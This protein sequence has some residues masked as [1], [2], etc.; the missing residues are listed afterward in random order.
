VTRS[1]GSLDQGARVVRRCAIYTRVATATD[2][3][4]ER[5]LLAAQRARC[6]TLIRQRASRGWQLV[7]ERYD[8][9]GCSGG[10]LDR[11][12]LG[13]LLAAIDAGSVDVVVATR[14]DRLCSSLLDAVHLLE[15]FR[16]A[17]AVFAAAEPVLIHSGV[18][19]LE[20][21][22]ATLLPPIPEEFA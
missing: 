13:R 18:A 12:A 15:R 8:D 16:R 5:R 22:R 19:R 11:P 10:H 4:E 20:P 6:K 7:P 9:G 1:A 2:L 3:D 21:R 14:I 17:G